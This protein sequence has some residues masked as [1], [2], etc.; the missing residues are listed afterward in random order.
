MISQKLAASRTIEDGTR[1]ITLTKIAGRLHDGSRNLAQL[2]EDLQAVNKVRCQPPL[3]RTEVNRIA[4]SFYK[5]SPSRPAKQPPS[6]EVLELVERLRVAVLHVRT[7]KGRGGGSDHNVYG[8]LLEVTEKH[9]WVS[10]HGNVCV[11]VSVRE[12][13]LEAGVSTKTCHAALRRLQ[14]A[15]LLYRVPMKTKGK[16]GVLVLRDVAEKR[17]DDAQTVNTQQEDHVYG[18]TVNGLCSILRRFRAGPGRITPIK[19]MH[20][21]ALFELGGEASAKELS[22]RLDRRPYTVKRT[23]TFL[24]ERGLAARSEGDRWRLPSRLVEGL[25]WA[26]LM[27]GSDE[28]HEA[29]RQQNKTDREAYFDAFPEYRKNFPVEEQEAAP[30]RDEQA[31]SF[32]LGY[33]SYIKPADGAFRH[34]RWE[35]VATSRTR[36]GPEIVAEF[37]RADD[38]APGCG[39]DLCVA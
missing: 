15:Q 2:E 36:P 12:L 30:N 13:A 7:W 1:N 24:W 3:A 14:A 38:H 9:G 18:L 19:A 28:S 22:E 39:C 16:A 25:A 17:H 5:K 23:M 21:L 6:E 27:D 26:Y 8:A 31:D 33:P 35:R 32:G 34:E 29:Q 11:S 10:G 4:K 37:A 20:L